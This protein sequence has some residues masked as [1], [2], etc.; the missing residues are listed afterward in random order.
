MRQL[1]GI[2]VSLILI[3]DFAMADVVRIVSWNASPSLYESIHR[4]S[5]DFSKLNS[6]LRPDILIVVEVAGEVEVKQ[7][8]NA[9]GWASYHAVVSDWARLRDRVYFALETAVVSKIPI[10]SVI[11]YDASPDGHHK[12]FTEKGAIDGIVSEE[13]LSSDGIKDFGEPLSRHDRGTMRIDFANGLTVFP[14]HLK[15]NRNGACIRLLD[16]VKTLKRSNFNIPA[17]ILKALDSGF[18]SATRE[19]IRNAR[20]RER[21]MAATVR[22]ANEAIHSQRIVLIAGDMNTSF[23]PGLAGKAVADCRLT[24]FGCTKGPLPHNACLGGDGYDD[25]LG[26]ILEEGLVGRTT[27]KILSAGL[28][29]TF[30]DKAFADYAIDHMA[31]PIG[32]AHQFANAIRGRELYGSDHFPIFT[33][34]TTQK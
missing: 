25:T 14:L 13:L 29:R 15:S 11:E 21:V 19:R 32:T 2:C 33:I 20:K 27:W 17:P 18:S 28:G 26:G 9:L 10:T 1:I 22:I 8:V 6:D 3:T 5:N 7:I 16:A 24:N 31:V 30:D 12:V 23:E 4:R 34:W